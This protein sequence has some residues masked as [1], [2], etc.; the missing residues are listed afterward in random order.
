MNQRRTFAIAAALLLAGSAWA[1][2]A[3]L[4]PELCC[5]LLDFEDTTPG[6]CVNEKYAEFGIHI[7]RDDG[8]CIHAVDWGATGYRTPSPPMVI[9]SF[10]GPGAPTPYTAVGVS[11]DRLANRISACYGN[12]A[13][14]SRL[15]FEAHGPRHSSSSR[16]PANGNRHIDQSRG[17]AVRTGQ[18]FNLA[19]W[20]FLDAGQVM[21]IDRLFVSFCPSSRQCP[22]L[23]LTE[24]GDDGRPNICE[25]EIPQTY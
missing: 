21:A 6:E 10:A 2:E 16:G 19:R 25:I 3:E 7:F 8:Q 14:G 17:A 12:D 22:I 15:F 24:A 9:G 23:P 13:P 1:G 18:A 20:S 11:L 5:F 4:D